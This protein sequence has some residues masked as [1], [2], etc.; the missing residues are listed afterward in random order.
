[1]C[2]FI[3]KSQKSVVRTS[4]IQLAAPCVCFFPYF[5]NICNLLLK[6]CLAT[7]LFVD[8]QY[9]TFQG[10]CVP[11]LILVLSAWKDKCVY[12]SP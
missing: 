12:T 7:Y 10:K 8:T 11:E 5:G 2:L 6:I 9:M 4:V 3:Y 1:M